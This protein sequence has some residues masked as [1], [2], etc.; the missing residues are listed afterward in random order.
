MAPLRRQTCLLFHSLRIRCSN[1]SKTF[2]I[3]NIQQFVKQNLI[4][5]IDRINS[6]RLKE[7]FSPLLFVPDLMLRFDHF[8]RLLLVSDARRGPRM[9]VITGRRPLLDVIHLLEVLLHLARMTVRRYF[10]LTIYMHD[11]FRNCC[12]RQTTFFLIS[13]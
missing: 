13:K 9:E 11:D 8:F 5:L 12:S 1:H 6:F 10:G 4:A 7:R 2:P 3:R